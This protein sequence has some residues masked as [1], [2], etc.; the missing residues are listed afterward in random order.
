M[1]KEIMKERGW[2]LSKNK[3]AVHFHK[4]LVKEGYLSDSDF[5]LFY[6]RNISKEKLL[7]KILISDDNSRN[8]FPE[9]ALQQFLEL[10]REI[11]GEYKEKST[12]DNEN[13]E[14]ISF[15]NNFSLKRS[16]DI[17]TIEMPSKSIEDF[18]IGNI[19]SISRISD[20]D[21]IKEEEWN[22]RKFVIKE[23]IFIIQN[24]FRFSYLLPF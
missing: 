19:E 21:T 6:Q 13:K 11:T 12:C 2:F 18:N 1:N 22:D 8:F 3:E 20:K 7:N 16:R 23:S 15:I 9:W 14:L 24:P 17:C 4:S 10:D 5:W